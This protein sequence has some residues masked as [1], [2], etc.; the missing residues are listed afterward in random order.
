MD[1]LQG[2][3]DESP[4]KISVDNQSDYMID[5][6]ETFESNIE[7]RKQARRKGVELFFDEE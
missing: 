3:G 1:V 6:V 2:D 4:L 5:F 7:K